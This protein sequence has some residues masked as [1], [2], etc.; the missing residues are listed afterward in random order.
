MTK[1]G[2]KKNKNLYLYSVLLVAYN[3]IS[4][5]SETGSRAGFAINDTRDE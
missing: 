2:A 3:H 4:S 5:I 1:Q